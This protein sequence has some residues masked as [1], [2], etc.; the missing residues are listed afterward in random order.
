MC[1]T[2]S[3]QAYM[4]NGHL[5]FSKR[6]RD[7]RLE[8]IDYRDEETGEPRG[9]ERYVDNTAVTISMPYNDRISYIVLHGVFKGELKQVGPFYLQ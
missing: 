8:F 4:G 7:P 2:I 3:D 9:G 1:P 5:L 6:I